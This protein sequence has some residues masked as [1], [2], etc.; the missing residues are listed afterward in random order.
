MSAAAAPERPLLARI[1]L[2]MV[3]SVLAV[4]VANFFLVVLIQPPLPPLYR[5]DAIAA[6]LVGGTDPSGTLVVSQAKAPPAADARG[7]GRPL[8]AELVRALNAAPDAVRLSVRGPMIPFPGGGGPPQGRATERGMLFGTFSAAL[9]QADGS[10]RT[11]SPRARLLSSWQWRGL[12]T[13]LATL[14]AVA[15]FAWFLARRLAAPISAFADAAERLGRDPRAA[16]LLLEGPREVQ[17]ATRAFNEM[18]ARLRRYV[19]DRTAMIGAIAHDLRTPL[20]RLAF[21][22]ENVP[23]SVRIK[24]EADIEEMRAMLTAVLD[25]VREMNAHQR[26]QRLD[27]RSLVESVANNMADLG[28]SVAVAAGDPV[29]IEGDP[30]ALRSLFANL[31][32]NAIQYGGAAGVVLAVQSGRAVVEIADE[33]PGLA[34]AELTR[35]FEPFYRGE[36]SRNRMTGGTGLGLAVVRTVVHAHGGDVVLENRLGGGLLARVTLPV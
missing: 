29:V 30:V 22:I 2:T 32:S 18:Q 36:P 5:I 35:V 15:P 31:L 1:F 8:H 27:L 20:M 21:R 12:I 25:F 34:P 11:V 10:W 14:A 7:P 17:A 33:G 4:Q 13:L 9:R 26:R 3:L 6:V 28:D 24:A 16:P 19:E 23:D